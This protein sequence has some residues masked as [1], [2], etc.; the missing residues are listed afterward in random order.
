[1]T[2]ASWNAGGH[3]LCFHRNRRATE[4]YPVL[5]TVEQLLSCAGRAWLYGTAVSA[6][7]TAPARGG[8]RKDMAAK[9]LEVNGTGYRWPDRPIVVVCIDGGDPAYIEH[10]LAAG[11]IP[12]VE[13]YMREGFHTVAHGTMPSFTCPNN[14]SIVTGRPASVHGVSGRGGRRS[15]S[16]RTGRSR[17]AGTSRCVR[18]RRPSRR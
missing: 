6:D 4:E 13:R 18:A 3:F 1:M 7:A 10:G 8:G 15:R 17:L 2:A 11:I 16:G 14:M 9:R 12:N 5:I